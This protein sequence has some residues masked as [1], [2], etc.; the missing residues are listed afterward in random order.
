MKTVNLKLSILLLLLIGSLV[1]AQTTEGVSIK[2]T[3]S[4]PHSSAMLDVESTTKGLLIPRVYLTGISSSSPVVSPALGLMV[5]NTNT[6]TTGME[7]GFYYWE[8]APTGHWEKMN[9]PT[10]W[11]KFS[12]TSNHIYN[13]LGPLGKVGVGTHASAPVYNFEVRSDT[14][15]HNVLFQSNG[16]ELRWGSRDFNGEIGAGPVNALVQ[17]SGTL[18]V[19]GCSPY[20]HRGMRLVQLYEPGDW[21]FGVT[22]WEKCKGATGNTDI[23]VSK[24]HL[25]IHTSTGDITIKSQNN[26][27]LTN[28]GIGG[29]TGTGSI[30]FRG[31]SGIYFQINGGTQ[32]SFAGGAFTP[33]SDSTLKKNIANEGPVLSK[34]LALKT[35]TYKYK[36]DPTGEVH[37]GLIAQ[38]VEQQ[39]PHFVPELKIFDR[40]S[41]GKYLETYQIKKGVQ[42][43]SMTSTLIKA[44]QE[45]QVMIEALKAR[46][47]ALESK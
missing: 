13:T 37:H 16:N 15:Q 34:L 5:F 45:Q 17:K 8:V 19:G 41:T 39:F 23:E 6:T 38:D 22:S 46:I 36:D 29:G 14:S 44:I 4:A 24:N 43:H 7:S 21:G 32:Y 26:V 2:T 28:E 30:Y 47:V 27:I 25:G 18:T 12:P 1:N 20:V 3:P 10:L 31:K 42:Y 35:V 9:S 33:P 11:T 40:D